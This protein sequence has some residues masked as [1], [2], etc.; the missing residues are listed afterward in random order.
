MTTSFDRMHNLRISPRA[1][2]RSSDRM[3]RI[4]M[5][6]KIMTESYSDRVESASCT[7]TLPKKRMTCRHFASIATLLPG[8]AW[9]FQLPASEGITPH[10]P[11]QKASWPRPALPTLY[12]AILPR[13]CRAA[14]CVT[15]LR[16]FMRCVGK[17]VSKVIAVKHAVLNADAAAGQANF[18]VTLELQK[19]GAGTW[20]PILDSNR[21]AEMTAGSEQA[22]E[23]NLLGLVTNSHVFSVTPPKEWKELQPKQKYRLIWRVRHELLSGARES[24]RSAAAATAQQSGVCFEHVQVRQHHHELTRRACNSKC[25]TCTRQYFCW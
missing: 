7:H 3:N 17:D 15:T 13:S 22:P 24:T 25:P 18:S 12:M 11:C 6:V 14:E 9:L 23:G 20:E 5:L 21:Q 10:F 4:D 1:Q 19:R 2:L 8:K 16:S